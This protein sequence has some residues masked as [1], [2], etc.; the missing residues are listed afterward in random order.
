MPARVAIMLLLP[1][2]GPEV[3]ESAEFVALIMMISSGVMGSRC[4]SR[5]RC[6]NKNND[7]MNEPHERARAKTAKP[8]LGGY[9]KWLLER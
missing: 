4:L 6:I 9:C 3:A 8:H 7:F 1:L 5:L 2:F